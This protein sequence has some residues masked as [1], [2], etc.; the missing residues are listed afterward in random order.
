[1]GERE[2]SRD[3]ARSLFLRK[4]RGRTLPK[5]GIDATIEQ[6][7]NDGYPLLARKER[8]PARLCV[9]HG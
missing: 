2:D 9:S 5:P 6:L 4:T 7:A 8:T 1:M 3:G